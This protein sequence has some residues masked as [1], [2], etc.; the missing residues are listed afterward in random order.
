MQKN[1]E[2]TSN[3]TM[4]KKKGGWLGWGTAQVVEQLPSIIE[5]QRF[6]NQYGDLGV[7]S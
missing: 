5:A 4:K 2:T 3:K 1:P 7:D 6:Q